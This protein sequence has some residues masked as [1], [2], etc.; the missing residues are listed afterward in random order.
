MDGTEEPTLLP[1]HPS[2]DSSASTYARDVPVRPWVPRSRVPGTGE[3]SRRLSVLVHTTR[4]VHD[5][6]G[7]SHVGRG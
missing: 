2:Q 1:G 3:G 4:A 5:P 6:G 7:L